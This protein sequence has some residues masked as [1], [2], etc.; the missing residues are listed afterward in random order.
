MLPHPAP[1]PL[2]I[3]DLVKLDSDDSGLAWF[4]GQLPAIDPDF[5]EADDPE[6]IAA[7]SLPPLTG[8]Q[9]TEITQLRKPR[10]RVP[11]SVRL[12]PRVIAWLK[13]KGDGYLSR[14]NDILI[15]LMEAE[16]QAAAKP[17]E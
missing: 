5:L 17:P 15:N 4:H 3:D 1:D 16:Q 12:D 9:L 13:S 14:I 8:E 11:V 7:A 6:R 2:T 10:N